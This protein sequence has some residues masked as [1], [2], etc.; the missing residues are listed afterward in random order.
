M[1]ILKSTDIDIFKPK[2][3]Y[4]SVKYCKI[5]PK[6]PFY[7]SYISKSTQGLFAKTMDCFNDSFYIDV[8]KDMLKEIFDNIKIDSENCEENNKF[9]VKD[10]EY[11]KIL[12][13]LNQDFSDCDWIK[14]LEEFSK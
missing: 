7:L 14:N 8:N 13:E 12:K 6:S 2:W 4:D 10:S 11:K 1:N 3:V 5:M 9:L